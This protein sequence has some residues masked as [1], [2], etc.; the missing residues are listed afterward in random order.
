MKSTIVTV[1]ASN[2]AAATAAILWDG[3]FNDLSSSADLLKWSWANQVGPYQYYIH[4]SSDVS[5]YVNLSP[6]YKNPADLGSKQGVKIT[7]DGTA[8][9]NGQTMRRTELIPQTSAAINKGKVFYHFS[10]MRSDVNPPAQTREHQIAFFES[11]F[12]ELKAGWI[13]GATGVFDPLLRW[14]IGGNT[15]WSVNWDAGV[16]HNVAYEIDFSAS[17]VGFWHSTG[18]ND[19]VQ[20]IAPRAASTSSNGAD[21]HL[22]VLEL[23]RDGYK[24]QTED[25]YFSG[26]YVEDG[27]ITTSV[28]GPG[29]TSGGG[30]SSS[31][32]S[33]TSTT[34]A[35]STV[36]TTRSSITTTTSSAATT[37]TASSCTAS[38]WAQCGGI[39]FTGCTVCESGTTCK[40][41]NDWYSQCL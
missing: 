13:S 14:C 28:S 8:Y 11:H 29:G 37:S 35:T 36:L 15:Q 20:V 3:R 5:A 33:A 7:L 10:I 16:W 6:N 40:Y 22:G 19:L 4:G 2:I 9:W 31:S 30:G 34:F 23:P 26:V 38:K 24:D 21:W 17:T 27:H 41:S 25:I 18:A 32:S 39:G 12:T 1:L